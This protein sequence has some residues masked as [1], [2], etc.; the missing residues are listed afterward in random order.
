MKQFLKYFLITFAIVSTLNACNKAMSDEFVSYNNNQLNDTIWTNSGYNSS[1]LNRIIF[2]EVTRNTTLVDSFDCQ[3]E[4]KL[5]FGDSI[6][7]SIPANSCIYNNGSPITSNSSIIKAE[8][9]LLKKKGDFVKYATPTTN[10]FTLLEA[11]N[12]CNIRLTKDGKEVSIAPNN[13]IK[14]K[15]KDSTASSNMKFF[16][17]NAI[18]YFKDSLFIWSPSNDGKVDVWK[19]N[20]SAGKTL[21]YEY[22]TNRIKWFGTANYVDSNV[23]KTKLN[24]ILSPNFTNKNTTVFAVLKN[25]KTVINLLSNNENRTFFTFNIPVNAEFTLVAIAKINNDYYLDSRVIKN[26]SSNPISLSPYKKSLAFILE[27]IDKL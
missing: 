5:S 7:I 12:Y 10:I 14:I 23:A 13:Q 26:A 25:S 9:T 2:P 15:I 8:I 3:L 1:S 4:G 11:S 20:S 27:F 24:V 19:D 22:T 6:Q 18:K 16:A 21:G 17:G